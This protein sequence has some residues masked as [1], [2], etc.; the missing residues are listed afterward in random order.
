MTVMPM[1]RRFLVALMLMA[2][3]AGVFGYAV[4]GAQAD[5]IIAL[6]RTALERWGEGNPDGVLGTYADQ[7]TYFDPTRNG[8]STD[9]QPWVPCWRRFG[10]N[11]YRPIRDGEPQSSVSRRHRG[12]DV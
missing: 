12:T 9:V 10:E 5:P 7:V 11:P 2:T 6:E 8:A 3:T 1:S 4:G